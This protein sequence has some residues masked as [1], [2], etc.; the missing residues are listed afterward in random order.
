MSGIDSLEREYA[1]PAAYSIQT[2]QPYYW[3]KGQSEADAPLYFYLLFDQSA[4]QIETYEALKAVLCVG[5]GPIRSATRYPAHVAPLLIPVGETKIS[6]ARPNPTENQVGDFMRDNYDKLQAA[7][8]MGRAG[9]PLHHVYLVATTVPSRVW[10][11]GMGVLHPSVFRAARIDDAGDNI[12]AALQSLIGEAMDGTIFSGPTVRDR[13]YVV[14]S[15]VEQ[16]GGV[17]LS[18]GASLVPGQAQASELKTTDRGV[19][20]P[21]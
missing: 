15:W 16:L 20:A 18:V 11:T 6:L 5:S 2:V 8:V 7:D 14:I 17:V 9:L 12:G 19:C 4:D 1:A 13:G 10:S 3:H 21:S